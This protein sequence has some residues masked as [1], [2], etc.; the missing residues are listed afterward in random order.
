MLKFIKMTTM[1]N[2]EVMPHNF[3]VGEFILAEIMHRTDSPSCIIINLNFSVILSTQMDIF[4]GKQAL[5]ILPDISHLFLT[6]LERSAS[7]LLIVHVVNC[8]S[9]S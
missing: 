7:D 9:N 5:Y 8:L 2:V 3:Q 1:L 6:E 4:K